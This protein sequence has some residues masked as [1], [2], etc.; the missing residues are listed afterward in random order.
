MKRAALLLAV[1]IALTALPARAV[2]RD[3][4]EGYA[5]GVADSCAGILLIEPEEYTFVLNLTKHR[6]HEA[7]KKCGPDKPYNTAWFNGTAEELRAAL[8][9][10]GWSE[11]YADCGNCR[12][13][14]LKGEEG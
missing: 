2:P 14:V 5:Q 3:Y 8:D 7:G 4:E 13:G 9:L 12:P 10:L 6:I 11:G 1:L